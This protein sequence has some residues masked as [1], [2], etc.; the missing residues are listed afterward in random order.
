MSNDK[1]DFKAH[2]AETVRISVVEH[3]EL[4]PE[5]SIQTHK[6]LG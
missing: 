3:V 5:E 6:E 4:K 1:F 2:L